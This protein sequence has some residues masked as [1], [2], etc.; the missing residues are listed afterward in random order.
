MSGWR[1]KNLEDFFSEVEMG[2]EGGAGELS[3][4]L[5]EEGGRGGRRR[6]TP[7]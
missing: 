1:R 2:S 4:E 7:E 6:G 3:P 5:E